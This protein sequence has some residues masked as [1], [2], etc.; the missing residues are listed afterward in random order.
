[1]SRTQTLKSYTTKTV[2]LAATP[3]VLQATQEFVK[4]ILIQAP[5][6]NTDFVYV[7]DSAAQLVAIAPG[8][9]ITFYGDNLDHGT[10]AKFDLSQI[11]VKVNVNGEKVNY[12]S[13]SGI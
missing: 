3:E 12:M 1:M 11:W 6:T 9:S 8:K 7:G 13:M 10:Y 5:A 2:A 4:S